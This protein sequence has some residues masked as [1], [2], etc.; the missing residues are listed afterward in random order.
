MAHHENDKLP[1]MVSQ[2]KHQIYC[3]DKFLNWRAQSALHNGAIFISRG[4]SLG[5]KMD[6]W[7]LSFITVE[8]KTSFSHLDVKTKSNAC[9]C[10]Y[11][12]LLLFFRK[13]TMKKEPLKKNC[14]SSRKLDW[15]L[16][17]H[18]IKV[19]NNLNSHPTWVWFKSWWLFWSHQGCEV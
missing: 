13:N 15:I 17:M 16:T 10:T 19:W 2:W 9:G 1:L 8:V 4:W 18:F 3:L 5:L 7:K 14:S 12:S 11:K 6:V